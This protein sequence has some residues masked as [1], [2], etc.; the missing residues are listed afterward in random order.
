M[1]FTSGP[2]DGIRI[3]IF[4]YIYMYIKVTLLLYIS[5][6]WGKFMFRFNSDIHFK[7][8]NGSVAIDGVA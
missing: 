1:M 3:I 4:G 8:L 7:W 2:V 6:C 5:F